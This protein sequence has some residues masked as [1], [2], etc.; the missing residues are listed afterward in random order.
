MLDSCDTQILD[1]DW[2][3]SI[4]NVLIIFVNIKNSIHYELIICTPL[5]SLSKSYAFIFQ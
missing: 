4:V 3:I 2:R 5:Y 1:V